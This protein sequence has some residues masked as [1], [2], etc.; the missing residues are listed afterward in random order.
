[1]HIRVSGAVA[2]PAS[3]ARKLRTG[4]SISRRRELRATRRGRVRRHR[5]WLHGA[6]YPLL[7]PLGRRYGVPFR[8]GSTYITPKA[9]SGDPLDITGM[10]GAGSAPRSVQGVRIT[11][12]L[13]RP[14]H[15]DPHPRRQPIAVP[16]H[17][18]QLELHPLRNVQ[19]CLV[20]A[21][22]GA[23]QKNRI[24]DVAAGSH[25]HLECAC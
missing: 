25:R 24:L 13:A 3:L 18:G 23:F 17:I 14:A 12:A 7:R 19:Q 20:R 16:A 6:S 21:V 15:L 2:A 1:M 10:G 5:P 11:P 8:P 4:P 9:V 22:V